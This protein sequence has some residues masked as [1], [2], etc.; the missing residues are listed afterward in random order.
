VLA[1]GPSCL[2]SQAVTSEQLLFLEAW[3]AVDR[4]YVDKSFNGQNWF[5]VWH[6]TTPALPWPLLHKICPNGQVMHSAAP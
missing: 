5:K 2:S 1:L 3:R 6:I 4:A